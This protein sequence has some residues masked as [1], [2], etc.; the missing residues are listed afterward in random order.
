MFPRE[1]FRRLV[2]CAGF[3][4]NRKRLALLS[5]CGAMVQRLARGPF[6]AEIRVRFP[7]ALP[8]WRRP[9]VSPGRRRTRCG[10][11]RLELEHD[12]CGGLGGVRG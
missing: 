11:S 3:F 8:I 1:V 2:N 12:A 4:D 7:L 9:R 6:K 10:T 5:R